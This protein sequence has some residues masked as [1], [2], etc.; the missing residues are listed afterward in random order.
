MALSMPSRFSG[1]SSHSDMIVH[2]LLEDKCLNE[3]LAFYREQDERSI[4]AVAYTKDHPDVQ[5]LARKKYEYMATQLSEHQ[6]I[7]AVRPDQ[8]VMR[9]TYR[10]G[11]DHLASTA[12]GPDDSDDV[13]GLDLPRLADSMELAPLQG[14]YEQLIANNR[15][16]PEVPE[17][18]RGYVDQCRYEKDFVHIARIGEGGFGKVYKAQ[19]KLDGGLYAVKRIL[20]KAKDIRKIQMHGPGALEALLRELRKLAECAHPNIVRYHAG[21]LEYTLPSPAS[22]DDE[23]VDTLDSYAEDDE[24]TDGVVTDDAAENDA[25]HRYNSDAVASARFSHSSTWDLSNM[26]DALAFGPIGPPV[27]L[28]PEPVLA[29]HIQMSLHP[30]TLAGFLEGIKADEPCVDDCYVGLRHCFHPLVSMK[31][32][33]AILDGVEYL[34]S[35]D[36]AHRDLKPT[37]IFLALQ[38]HRTPTCIDLGACNNCVAGEREK[39]LSKG[40]YL[41]VCIGDFGLAMDMIEQSE[42][43]R[44][45]KNLGTV[46]YR[47]ENTTDLPLRTLDLYALG[48]ITFELL[49][50]LSTGFERVT[51]L[52]AIRE[53]TVVKPEGSAYKGV[54]KFIHDLTAGCRESQLTCDDVRERVRRLEKLLE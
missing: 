36:M 44:G 24:E 1:P 39:W 16:I 9:E 11:L 51:E 50:P 48:V 28:S 6:L 47:P 10:K 54:R 13:D 33:L 15:L 49:F 40:R 45:L 4:N 26:Q 8:N 32:F 37:N 2:A 29:L 18:L 35:R 19:H 38:D 31:V 12:P 53:G 14:A 42:S 20:F 52:S 7:N 30:F 43:D 41:T 22:S 27:E 5:H 21:W 17:V 23:Y 3:A 25:A 34:H 46:L